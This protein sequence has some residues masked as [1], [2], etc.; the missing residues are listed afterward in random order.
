MCSV[1]SFCQV[2]LSGEEQPQLVRQHVP[3]FVALFVHHRQ[4]HRAQPLRVG[5]STLDRAG[6]RGPLAHH[7]VVAHL[8]EDPRL[9]HQM[10]RNPLLPRPGEKSSPAETGCSR[11]VHDLEA[12]DGGLVVVG[13]FR[14]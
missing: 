8:P 5:L 4:G 12:R 9:P 6:V 13:I 1:I 3:V 14:L 11:L 7:V 10:R 2:H